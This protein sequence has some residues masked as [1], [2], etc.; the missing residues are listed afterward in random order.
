MV[1]STLHWSNIVNGFSGAE[2]LGY[3][4]TMQTLDQLPAASAFGILNK[5]S[6]NIL[7]IHA[8][9]KPERKE[10]IKN[11]FLNSDRVMIQN[12]DRDQFLV[13]LKADSW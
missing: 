13:I 12:I 1:D 9:V 7:A 10:E 5:Y 11:Y 4:E 3:K 2:P 6:V 8:D